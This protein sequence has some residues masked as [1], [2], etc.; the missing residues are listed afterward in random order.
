MVE[1]VTKILEWL[2]AK[3]VDAD[4][5]IGGNS[6]F[7]NDAAAAEDAEVTADGLRREPQRGG[8]VAGA[9]GLA[10]QEIYDRSTGFIG[11]GS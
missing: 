5:G 3:V 1:P 9:A 11:E 2:L 8:D 4:A 7:T 6:L 10:A